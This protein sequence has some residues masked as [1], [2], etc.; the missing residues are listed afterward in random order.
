[1]R[2]LILIIFISLIWNSSAFA[3]CIGGNCVNGK[4]TWEWPNGNKYVGEFKDSKLNGEGIYTSLKGYK[5]VGQWKNGKM[6]GQGTGTFP[7][8]KKLIGE[9]KDGKFIK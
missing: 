4:G 5:Y 2:K 6:E 8:G 1:M 9:W 3:R 7:D